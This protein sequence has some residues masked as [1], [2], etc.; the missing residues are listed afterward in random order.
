MFK[1]GFLLTVFFTALFGGIYPCVVYLIGNLFFPFHAKGSLLFSPQEQCYIGSELIA[2]GF[3]SARY[4]H[5]RPS[6][7][8]HKPYNAMRSGASE[9]GPTMRRL[10]DTNLQ[11]ASH[12]RTWNHLDTDMYVPI[13]AITASSSG[14]DPH[15]SVS[16]ALLQAPRVAKARKMQEDAVHVLIAQCTE[17]PTFGILG[18]ARVHVLKLNLALDK[19]VIEKD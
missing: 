2:Q 11:R 19:T 9:L 13:D 4:F 10:I 8:R 16:N 5:S 1:S 18:E 3:Q 6:D 12:Y 17:R 15:I 14:L 7:T